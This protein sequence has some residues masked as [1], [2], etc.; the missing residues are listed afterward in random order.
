M[1]PVNVEPN[2]MS[3]ARCLDSRKRGN[4]LHG[5]P[6]P[7]DSLN[8]EVNMSTEKPTHTPGPWTVD[9]N[10]RAIFA[11]DGVLAEVYGSMSADSRDR[12]TCEANARLIAEA[13]AM[14]EALR[15]VEH[16]LSSM[17]DMGAKV[18]LEGVRATIAR[19]E[20]VQS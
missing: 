8:V 19:A 14:L 4:V 16:Y 15:D 13:P 5:M 7:G 2:A 20:G 17:G 9:G 18:T 11:S 12:E 3:F 6:R 10:R 1:A